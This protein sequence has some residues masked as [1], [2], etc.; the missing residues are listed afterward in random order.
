LS[1][2]FS[3]YFPSILP[4]NPANTAGWF[5]GVALQRSGKSRQKTT[6]PCDLVIHRK[7]IPRSVERFKNRVEATFLAI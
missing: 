6:V 1:I 7:L 5:A 2:S 4:P 3:V